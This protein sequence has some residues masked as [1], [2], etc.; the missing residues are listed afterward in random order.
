MSQPMHQLRTD[1]YGSTSY[2]GY[3]IKSFPFCT[4]GGG[5][6]AR[7]APLIEMPYKHFHVFLA[8]DLLTPLHEDASQY[9]AEC[10]VDSIT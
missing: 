6:A 1:Y 8:N 10:H 2:K 4:S 5:F 7:G 9:Q 3:V